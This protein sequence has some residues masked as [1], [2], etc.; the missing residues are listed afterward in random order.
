MRIIFFATILIANVTF[1]LH[2]VYKV[3]Q[4][5]RLVF[6]K[7]MEKVYLVF[8]LCKNRNKLELSKIKNHEKE[9]HEI[10]NDDFHSSKLLFKNLIYYS[11]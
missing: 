1:L 6:I 3:Y 8:C 10:F 11:A 7:K 4:E 9:M 2:W 5:F